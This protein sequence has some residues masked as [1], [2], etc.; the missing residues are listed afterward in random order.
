MNTDVKDLYQL[1]RDLEQTAEYL[2]ILQERLIDLTLA[3]IGEIET[4]AAALRQKNT[5]Q[6][7][8]TPGFAF[9]GEG[10]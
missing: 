4:L 2:S 7:Q 5:S 8:T 3:K 10:G 6:P 1:I 9:D